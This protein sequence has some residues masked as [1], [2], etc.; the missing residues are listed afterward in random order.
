MA[1]VGSSR[2]LLL[3]RRS[4]REFF[5]DRAPQFAAAISFHVFFSLFP[6]AILFVAVVGLALRDES[7][8]DHVLDLLVNAF[9]VSD[10]GRN[11][12][13]NTLRS[14]TGGLSALGFLSVIGLLWSASG[15]MAAVR[16]ALN[17]AW[18]LETGRSFVH[19]KL[20]D[21][22]LVAAAGLLV[23]ISLALTVA[24]RVVSKIST[25]AAD[26]LGPLSSSAGVFTWLLGLLAPFTVSFLAFAFL[27][28]VVPA[29]DVRLTEI[30]PGALFA[31]IGFETLKNG[32]AVYLAHFADYNAVYGSLGAVIAFLVFVNLASNLF[33]FGAEIA[34]EWPRLP[35]N[36][37][38]SS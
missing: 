16:A 25:G 23:L 8:R 26:A 15:L 11:D 18:D 3:A 22:L 24:V 19:G 14:V 2:L 28:R 1:G 20:A 35:Q 33:L 36:Q 6:L 9:P 37:Q 10:Q 17:A 34:S 30:W 5:D 29:T 12:I 13:S 27:Y 32:F 38:R 21:L 4:L 7:T 31:A